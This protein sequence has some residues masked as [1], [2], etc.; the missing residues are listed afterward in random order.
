MVASNIREQCALLSW[1]R[2]VTRGLA[3]HPDLMGFCHRFTHNGYIVEI[4]LPDASKVKDR[5]GIGV[6]ATIGSRRSSGGEPLE[7]K[8]LQV[9]VQVNMSE[10]LWIDSDVFNRDPVAYELFS[11]QEQ[12]QFENVCK[13]HEQIAKRSFEYWLSIMRYALGDYRIGRIEVKGNE[14]GWSTRLKDIEKERT[15]WIQKGVFA[16]TGCRV[17]MPT[18]WLVVQDLLD[19]NI[20]PPIFISLKH[21]AEESMCNGDYRKSLI[22]LAMCCETFLRYC[23]LAS[24]PKELDKNIVN[25]IEELN[26][27]QYVTK[28]FKSLLL[29]EPDIKEYKE[30]SE[31]L[32]SLF[33]KRN[34]ILH[35][36]NIEGATKENCERFF[37]VA[38]KL[39]SLRKNISRIILN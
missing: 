22:E 6:V 30:I 34:K 13:A 5:P 25:A 15:V 3:V 35:M 29:T 17:V 37:E 2:F 27:N 7:F 4:K 16:V 23:V 26:I 12:R 11:E 21:D 10:T 19:K 38:K 1:N 33:N 31:E 18:E 36:G 14:S 28:H 39:I 32:S 24:L 9:D 8:I 20:L